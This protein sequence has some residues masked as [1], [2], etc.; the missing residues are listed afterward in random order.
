MQQGLGFIF[1]EAE[2][3]GGRTLD[4][5]DIDF[6]CEWAAVAGSQRSRR[7][8]KS[9]D[10]PTASDRSQLAI[11]GPTGK[12]VQYARKPPGGVSRDRQKSAWLRLISGQPT[13]KPARSLGI[14][15]DGRSLPY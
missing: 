8:T 12:L 7:A 1:D 6:S 4:W 5:H 9:A 11:A 15:I 10:A 3:S 13:P 2:V 14:P